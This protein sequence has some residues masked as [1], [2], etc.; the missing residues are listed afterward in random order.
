MKK[1]FILSWK[2]SIQPRK[3]RKYIYNAPLHVA[4]S[5]L[6]ANLSKDLRT[7]YGTR[8]MRIR[9]GDKV[10]V[11]RGQYKGLEGVVDRVSIKYTQIYVNGVD[12]IRKDGTKRLLPLI[13]SNVK[14]IE[15]DNSDKKRL[16]ISGK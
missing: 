14:I 15:L 2:K 6:S 10:K 11:M 9:K 16:T 1:S 5:F 8:S 12:Y 3:Q 4:G 13:P 7:K